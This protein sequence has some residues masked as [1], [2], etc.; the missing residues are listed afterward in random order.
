MATL[1]NKDEVLIVGQYEDILTCPVCNCQDR[2]IFIKHKNYQLLKCKMCKL[3][4]QTPRKR[5]EYLDN[6]YINNVSS[7]ADYYESTFIFDKLTFRKRLLKVL[8]LININPEGK[9]IL[10]IGCNIGSFLSAAKELG[11][12]PTGIEPNPAAAQY[13]KERNYDIINS[14]FDPNVLT[15]KEGFFDIIHM[16]DITEHVAR[17]L[18]LIKSV[19]TFTKPGG[20]MLISTPNIDSSIARMFQIK[21]NEHIFYFDK[22]SL[23]YLILNAG[24]FHIKTYITSRKRDIKSMK[25]STSFQNVRNKFILNCVESFHVG[26]IVTEILKYVA[27]DEILLIAKNPD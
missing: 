26:E 21:P 3:I 5:N 22:E 4:Y 8:K 23:E 14:F 9:K 18:E 11:F 1:N 15:G 25:Y 6:Q 10:D 19:K 13:C 12:S 16:G 2:V 17:P 7:R 27:N 20:Y 24:L